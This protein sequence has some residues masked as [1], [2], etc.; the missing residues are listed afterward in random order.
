MTEELPTTFPAPSIT[1]TLIVFGHAC[2]PET[3]PENHPVVSEV[4][5]PFFS[6]PT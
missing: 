4:V 2:K 3:V 5:D 1:S 6:A